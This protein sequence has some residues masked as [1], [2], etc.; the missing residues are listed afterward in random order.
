MAILFD[1]KV[2]FD[3]EN[4]NTA[5]NIWFAYCTLNSP[6]IGEIWQYTSCIKVYL[7]FAFLQRKQGLP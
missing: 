1:K 7:I 3:W 6:V 2:V 5:G 4:K